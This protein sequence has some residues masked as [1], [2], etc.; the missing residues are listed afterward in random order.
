MSHAIASLAGGCFWC[1]ESVF[2]RLRGVSSAVSGYMGGHTANPTYEDICNGDTGHAE[3]VRVNYDSDEVSF[4]ELLEVFFTL[5]DPTQL[6]RQGNDVGTQYRSAIFWHTPDQKA[7]AEAVI[8]ELTAA[9]QFG[10]PIV[11]ELSEATTFY[12]AEGYHQGYFEQNPNQPYCQY[13]VAPK[14]AKARAKYAAR[15]KD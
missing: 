7:E 3:V 1:I 5:H 8:A 2:N 13:V 11:T 6:N 12:P 4:R 9:G 15:L 10:A 14:V